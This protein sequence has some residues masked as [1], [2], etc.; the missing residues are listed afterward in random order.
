VSARLEGEDDASDGIGLFL[1]KPKAAGVT[2]RS[3]RTMD[4]MVACDL[5]LEGVKLDETDVL[6]VPGKAHALL[7]EVLDFAT[8]LSCAEAVGVIGYA[9]AQTLDYLKT[10]RQFGRSIGSN[11]ALQHRMVELMITLEQTRSMACLACVKVDTETDARPR[12]RAVSAAQIRIAEACRLVSQESVQMHGGIGM[13]EELKL[14]HCFRRL[15]VLGQQF[16][17]IDFHLDRFAR[18]DR[19]LQ[20]QDAE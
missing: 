15:V 11:Q 19:E 6:G 5:R 20:C 16:G 1:V 2:Q 18:L 4:G 3:F 14:S 17:D 12:A 8:A 13:T 10:R 9:N 7:D